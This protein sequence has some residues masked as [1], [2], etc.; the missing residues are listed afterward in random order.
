MPQPPPQQSQQNQSPPIK[1]DQWDEI[2]LG[3]LHTQDAS[4]LRELLSHTN[5]ELIMPLN[6]PALVSQAVILT[7][8][9]R[10]RGLLF[11]FFSLVSST[12]QLSAV[13]SETPPNDEAFKNALWWL[14]R[15][16]ALL[17]PEVPFMA[18]A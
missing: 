3:V 15:T 17:R 8:V 14:Q 12:P 11:F 7:L 2:Y 16:S 6:G 18:I 10:V 4:K 9:H 5:P 13:I 1:A